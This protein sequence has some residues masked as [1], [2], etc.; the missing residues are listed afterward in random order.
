M[1]TGIGQHSPFGWVVLISNMTRW[2]LIPPSVTVYLSARLSFVFEVSLSFGYR[3]GYGTGY[4]GRSLEFF[5]SLV[6][7]F[8]LGLDL[9]VPNVP[10]SWQAIEN[11]TTRRANNPQRPTTVFVLE[12]RVKLA[13]DEIDSQPEREGER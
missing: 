4:R 11:I 6:D 9:F 8:R 7:N 3:V 2:S 5:F 1:P 13:H 12:L 10:F